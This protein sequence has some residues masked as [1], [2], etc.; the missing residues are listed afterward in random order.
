[1]SVLL[2]ASTLTPVVEA[3]FAPGRKSMRRGQELIVV[4]RSELLTTLMYRP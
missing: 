3:W 4:I 1:M 2:M